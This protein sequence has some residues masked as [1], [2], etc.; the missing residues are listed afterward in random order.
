MPYGSYGERMNAAGGTRRL[1]VAGA[2]GLIGAQVVQIATAAGHE[3]VPLCRSCGVDLTDP[4]T[5]GNRLEGVDAV[6]DVTRPSVMG[7]DEA[8]AFF[9]T[10]AKNLGQAAS[11]AGVRRTIVLSIVGIDQSQD[12]G[13]YIATLAHED[14]TRSFSP[15]PRV[16]RATQFHEFPSQVLGW[17]RQDGRAEI[18][19]MPTQPVASVEV[20]RQLL[21][22]AN[23]IGDH[24]CD[25]A[26]PQPERLVD[27][28][29]QL[30]TL[31]GDDVDVVP[32]AV[33]ASMA[34]GSTL[35]GPGALL[36]GVDWHTWATATYG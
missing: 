2:T 5:I 25:I 16:L 11:T 6:I 18:M 24:D 31:T 21:Q 35:P 12:F 20:A 17:S 22:M 19:D 36:R 32:G 26:G 7:T 3:V 4:A 34:A 15:G 27:L 9:T 14:A 10:V 1:A 13:W 28:V 8:V 30:V 29:R 33:P 23:D